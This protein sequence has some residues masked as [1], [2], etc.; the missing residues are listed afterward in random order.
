MANGLAQPA[1]DTLPSGAGNAQTTVISVDAMGG[2][3]GPAAVV[4]GLGIS[5]AQNRDVSFI[6]HGDLAVL[7]PLVDRQPGLSG[8]VTLVHADRVVTMNDKPSQVMRHGEGT[9]MWSAIDSVKSGAAQ[10]AVSCGNT[11][12]LMAV[13]MIRLRKVAGV[14]RPAIACLWPSRNPGGFNVMLDVGAGIEAEAEDLLQFA[15]MGAAYA[16]NGLALAR[17]RVGLLNVGTEEHKGRAELKAAHDRMTEAAEAGG[18]DFVGFVEGGDIPSNRVDVIVTDGFNGNVA[19]KTGEGTAKLIA[20]FLKEA[21]GAGIL[22]KFAAL[23]AMNS[24]KRLQRRID[25]RRV[26]GGVFLGLNGTVVKSHGSADETGVAAA[27]GLAI[28]LARTG[29]VDRLAA[30]VASTGRAGQDAAARGAA[31]AATGD[32]TEA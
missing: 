14:N 2:D 27:I 6:L 8:R 31:G 28:Q 29:F 20:D 23:L 11:G 7:R 10:A 1:T 18:F 19:L 21:F 30:R 32:G 5:A 4:A 13:S 25:P 17:P 15:T 26:N 24:L 9:S 3:R 12:A 16:R 22:S